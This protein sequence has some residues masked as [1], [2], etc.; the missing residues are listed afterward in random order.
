[1]RYVP[2]TVRGDRRIL[3]DLE[4]IATVHEPHGV[5]YDTFVLPLSIC[6][7]EGAD[8]QGLQRRAGTSH[9][10]RFSRLRLPVPAR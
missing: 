1:M 9:V 8:V 6:A 4:R 7:V 10:C 5:V 2:F 3:N